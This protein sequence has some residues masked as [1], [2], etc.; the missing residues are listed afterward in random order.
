MCVKRMVFCYF[1]IILFGCA[2]AKQEE[3]TDLN[4][5]NQRSSLLQKLGD[6]TRRNRIEAITN[7]TKLDSTVIPELLNALNNKKQL[8][9]IYSAIAL[10][11]YI[12]Q[13]STAA[14]AGLDVL[15]S[16]LMNGYKKQDWD[17]K[18]DIVNSL[19][20]LG[21]CARKA[22]GAISAAVDASGKEFILYIQSHQ[23][24][25]IK[26]NEWGAEGDLPPYPFILTRFNKDG[27]DALKII[28]GEED[29]NAE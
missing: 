8:V 12:N 28:R 27:S 1:M 22:E 17:I 14:V 16:E 11:N 13:D 29:V 21:S 26:N 24:I 20:K 4:Q 7:L 10:T 3:P 23:T 6:K 25:E 5:S 9:R 2:V 18:V 15:I 19:A